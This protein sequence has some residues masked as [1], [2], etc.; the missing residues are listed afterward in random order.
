M[1]V[2]PSRAISIESI[3]GRENGR[4][5]F[6]STGVGKRTYR[7]CRCKVLLTDDLQRSVPQSPAGMGAGLGPG[8]RNRDGRLK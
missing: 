8:I 2:S 4:T 7:N 1:E 6:A 3:H 5:P